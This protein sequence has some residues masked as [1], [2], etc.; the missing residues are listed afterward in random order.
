MTYYVS[1][2][3]LNVTHSLTLGCIV[4]PQLKIPVGATADRSHNAADWRCLRQA[5]A[6]VNTL[7]SLQ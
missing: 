1:S 5:V 4:D 2:G 7:S 6:R 3:T